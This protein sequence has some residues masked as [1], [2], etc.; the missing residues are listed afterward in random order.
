MKT[1]IILCI[2]AIVSVV[3]CSS[4]ALQEDGSPA[5]APKFEVL[6]RSE[7]IAASQECEAAGMRPT[8]AYASQYYNG[9]RFRVPVT[10]N[11]EPVYGRK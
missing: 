6:S 10:V 3:G 8:V 9:T 4:V 1:N 11:C 5:A 2:L 7:V